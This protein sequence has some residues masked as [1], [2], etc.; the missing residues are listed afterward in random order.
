MWE[1][2]SHNVETL[3]INKAKALADQVVTLRK[4]YTQEVVSRAKKAGL[5]INYDWAVMP[6]TLPLPATFTNELGKQIF[7]ACDTQTPHNA[8]L[9]EAQV[10]ELFMHSEKGFE[11]LVLKN[12]TE[13]AINRFIDILD[14]FSD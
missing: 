14:D 6:N 1:V 11:D 9:I 10:S 7:A 12:T 2:N 3:G 5:R 4:F 8:M 13:D